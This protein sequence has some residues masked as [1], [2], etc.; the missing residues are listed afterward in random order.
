MSLWD[1]RLFPLAYVNAPRFL[2]TFAGNNNIIKL[3]NDMRRGSHRFDLF[4]SD[5][6]ILY[7]KIDK[8]KI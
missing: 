3:L 6:S 1:K 4:L 7:N 2:F 8:K 5:K